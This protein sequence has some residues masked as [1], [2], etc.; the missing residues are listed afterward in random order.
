MFDAGYKFSLRQ[1]NTP[2]HK[3][4]VREYI[5]QFRTSARK[6]YIVTVEE[7]PL[8]IFVPKFYP[9]SEKNNPN[10][11]AV[12]TDEY[13]ASRIIRTTID[14]MLFIYQKNPE[15]SFAWLGVATAMRNK[16]ESRSFTQCYR[17]YKN[18][19]LNFFSEEN[20]LHY[21]DYV[22]STYLLINKT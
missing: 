14:I 16:K 18:L 1:Q 12:L 3:D 13:K 11:F 9:S 22:T 7:Y 6:R 8:Q 15:A 20:W 21:D 5:F 17:I 19:M 2:E 10:R 4:W